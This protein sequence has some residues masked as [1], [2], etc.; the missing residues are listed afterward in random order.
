MRLGATAAHHGS[1]DA[2]IPQCDAQS[3]GRCGA[4]GACRVPGLQ[5]H[6][7]HGDSRARRLAHAALGLEGR[8]KRGGARVIV[9][10]RD[11]EILL[12]LPTA[13]AKYERE[14]LSHADYNSFQQLTRII[15]ASYRTRRPKS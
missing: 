2:R 12:L 14:D 8:G 1:R 13:F 5:P 9:F 3:Y 6:G 7:G 11:L 4:G 15:V 10:Y